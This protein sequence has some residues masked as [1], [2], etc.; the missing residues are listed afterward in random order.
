M[1]CNRGLYRVRK[2]ELIDFADGRVK[3]ITCLAYDQSDGMPSSECNGGTWPA[4]IKTRDGKLWFP[5]MG[6]VA[7]I[8]P[9]SIRANTQPPPVVIEVIRVE[10]LS[11]PVEFM[12]SAIGAS[13]GPQS[14]IQIRPGHENFEIQYTALSF[15]N[16]ENLRFKYKLVGADRDWVEAGARRTAYFSHVSPGEYTFK[17]IAA[18]SDGVWNLA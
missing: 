6:G 1:S 13:A 16:S 10:N 2:Q 15:I 17:V 7:V 11:V 18:N 3:T 12:Q 8:D 9:A 5:T 14:A 4:G